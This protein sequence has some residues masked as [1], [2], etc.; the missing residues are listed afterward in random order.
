MAGIHQKATGNPMS[1]TVTYRIRHGIASYAQLV[2]RAP[3]APSTQRK[4]TR[5]LFI[6]APSQPPAR[7]GPAHSWIAP[8]DAGHSS[9]RHTSHSPPELR[10]AAE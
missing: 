3:T 5:Q 6:A 10:E 4:F 9:L 7:P 2:V 1:A 8:Q